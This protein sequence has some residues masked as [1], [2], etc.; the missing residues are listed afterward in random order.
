MTPAA[1]KAAGGREAPR[2][3][4]ICNSTCGLYTV[5]S[6]VS[7]T[8]FANCTYTKKIFSG[9]A[10]EKFASTNQEILFIINLILYSYSYLILKILS[11]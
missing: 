9:S 8:T 3:N 4:Y 1:A 10:Y 6:H 5:N 7:S 11:F 2:Y